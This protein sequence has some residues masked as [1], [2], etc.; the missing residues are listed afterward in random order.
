MKS[1]SRLIAAAIGGVFALSPALGTEPQH[2]MDHPAGHQMDLCGMPAGEGVINAI[3][4]KKSKVNISHKPIVS[5]GYKD[6]TMDF[7][8]L[9]PVDFS[10]FADGERVHF[11]LQEGKNKSYAIAAMC[12]LDVDEGVQKACMAQMH[13]TA[14]QSAADS[15]KSC[16]MDGM[17]GMDGMNGMDHGDM[18]DKGAAAQPDHGS[19]H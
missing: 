18:G 1:Q 12:S 15:G 3:D 16:S 5:I 11:M 13:N 4:V 2:K 6:M 8:A 10:S 7:A 14:M 9:K 17:E 19:R